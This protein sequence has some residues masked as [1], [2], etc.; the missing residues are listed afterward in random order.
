LLPFP[1]TFRIYGIVEL[2]ALRGIT[3]ATGSKV[4]NVSV[5]IP[6]FNRPASSTRL[7]AALIPQVLSRNFDGSVEVIMVDD[8]SRELDHNQLL[9]KLNDYPDGI[10]RLISR[11]SSGGPSAARNTGILKAG[12]DLLVFLDDDC[13]PGDSYLSETVRIHAKYPQVL[14]ING[15]LRALRNDS[16][17]QFWFH[18][19]SHA[20]NTGEGELYRIHRI[21]S[22]NFSIKRSLLESFNPL[23]DENLPSREDYDLYLR[24]SM[25][26]IPIFKADSIHA[27]IECRR[28]LRELLRQRAWYRHGETRLRQKYSDAFLRE[29]QSGPYPRP[30]LAFIHIHI[31]LYLDRMVRSLPKRSDSL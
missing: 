9:E 24:L 13:I 27:I 23:F 20:F 8:H 12:G 25:A 6:T 18:Y 11:A 16:I 4:M 1:E 3:P 2:G 21:S 14:L 29:K 7:L 31:L 28:T 10:L 17:S 26:G 19:Y 5:I 15:N 22:G 30:S